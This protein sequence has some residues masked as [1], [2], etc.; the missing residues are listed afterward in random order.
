M[1]KYKG[2]NGEELDLAS[3][4]VCFIVIMNSS[5]DVE[6]VASSFFVVNTVSWIPYGNTSEFLWFGFILFS[7]GENSRPIESEQS[8]NV[9]NEQ[10]KEAATTEVVGKAVEST[11]VAGAV[12][13]TV[14]SSNNSCRLLQVQQERCIAAGA[15]PVT[16]K[17]IYNET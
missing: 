2:D 8:K 4:V 1:S 14:S 7:D 13:T 9:N 16:S 12:M 5:V 17:Y 10:N 6:I 15:S 3:V 11:D